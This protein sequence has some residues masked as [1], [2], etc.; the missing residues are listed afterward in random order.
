MALKLMYITNRPEVAVIAQDAGVDR[1]FVDM[2]Y[3]GKDQ[4]QGGMNTAQNHHTLED[5]KRIREVVDRAELM[6]RVNPIHEKS[7]TSSSS[8]EEIEAVLQCGA[9]VIMLPY[10]K[11]VQEIRRF[12]DIVDHRAKVFPLLETPE[13]VECMDE[14]LRIEGIDEIHFGLNDLG[15][16]YGKQFLF[17]LLADGTVEKLC[18][19]AKAAGIPY[20]F[21]GVARPGH[22]L[23]PA[24]KIIR[25]HYYYGSSRVILSRAFCNANLVTDT[26][27]IAET[28]RNGIRAIREVEQECMEQLSCPDKGQRYFEENHREVIRVVDSICGR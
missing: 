4:R 2:E 23:L 8:E 28:F 27:Q 5:V 15:I 11:T 13:A 10:F 6:V 21:G 20:G 12:I 17:E 7:E 1:I 26:D 9:E 25:D 19:K 18:A 16:G 14:I 3:N 22:G 24:E